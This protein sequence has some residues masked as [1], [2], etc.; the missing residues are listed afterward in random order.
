MRGLLTVGGLVLVGAT[1]GMACEIPTVVQIPETRDI[2]SRAPAIEAETQEYV[3]AMVAYT[4]CLK[5][6]I[7]AGGGEES[8]ALFQSL[9]VQ[10]HNSAVAEVKAVMDL[11]AER[12][13]PLQDAEISE[14][15]RGTDDIRRS[16]APA[17]VQGRAP[18]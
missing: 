15:P 17:P 4:D 16:G 7:E 9:L 10:R 5:A 2:G 3:Q 6:E 18:Q 14:A 11:Y 1:R 12:V 8:P 13:G